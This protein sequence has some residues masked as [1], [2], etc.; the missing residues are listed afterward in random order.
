MKIREFKIEDTET[1]VALWTKCDLVK[2]WNNPYKDITTK[3]AQ[4]ADLFLVAEVGQ[5]IVA[6]VMGG[7]EGHRGWANYL[8][9]EPSMQGNGYG[10]QLMAELELRLKE[11]GCPKINLQVRSSNKKV[12]EFYL[13]QGFQ[14]DDSVSLGKRLDGVN[15]QA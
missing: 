10:Q 5:S 9:V 4:G 2:P 3:L 8:V 14:V 1:I 15:Y 6:S 13:S 12:I 11:K 7:Y